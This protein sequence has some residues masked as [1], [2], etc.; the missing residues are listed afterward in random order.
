[1]RFGIAQIVVLAAFL[2]PGVPRVYG[3]AASLAD[4]DTCPQL[5]DEQ[6]AGPEITIVEVNF[7]GAS[8]VSLADQEQIATSIIKENS[9][10]TILDQVTDEAL[11]RARSGW[12]DRGYFKA[13]V[14]GDVTT[15]ARTPLSL[16][17]ALNVHVDEGQ[18]YRLGGITFKNNNAISNA[19]TLREFFPI[20]DGDVFSREKVATGIQKLRTAYAELGYINFRSIPNTVYDEEK[21]LIYLDVDIDEGMQFRVGGVHIVGLSEP[22]LSKVL[23]DFSMQRG[24]VYNERIFELFLLKHGDEFHGISG[25]SRHLDERSGVVTFTFDFRPCLGD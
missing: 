25:L 2:L 15:A 7:S 18:Q 10:G 3:Q 14:T 9:R 8:Q 19:A 21:R 17:L 11:E 22:R 5:E 12:Q 13:E 16:R 23:A 24:Q 1:M 20:K 6:N 4:R